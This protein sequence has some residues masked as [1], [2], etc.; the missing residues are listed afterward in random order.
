MSVSLIDRNDTNVN[1]MLYTS[2][3]SVNIEQMQYIFLL[4]IRLR[5][6]FLFSICSHF[7]II[8]DCRVYLNT[9]IQDLHLTMGLV[10]HNVYLNDWI[11]FF[12]RW[13]K[14]HHYNNLWLSTNCLKYNCIHFNLTFRT[15]RNII[16]EIVTNEQH[17]NCFGL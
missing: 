1:H 7:E 14:K 15:E 9:I 4:M 11:H 2:N 3:N 5:L 17:I 6:L 13:I 10:A 8:N 16:Y 12:F